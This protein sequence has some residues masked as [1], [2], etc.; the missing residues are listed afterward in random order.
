M[1]KE[2]KNRLQVLLFVIIFL[3]IILFQDDVR[4]YFSPKEDGA[5]VNTNPPSFPTGNN[6]GNTTNTPGGSTNGNGGTSGS[7]G[8]GTTGTDNGDIGG[9]GETGGD[10]TTGTGNDSGP[11]YVRKEIKLPP[12]SGGSSYTGTGGSGGSTSGAVYTQTATT[13]P[14]NPFGE[15]QRA[16]DARTVEAKL[17]TCVARYGN[18]EFCDKPASLILEV[19]ERYPE[20]S[21][22]G[23]MERAPVI[24]RLI[25]SQILGDPGGIEGGTVPF[26]PT[27]VQ[28]GGSII[29]NMGHMCYDAGNST[30]DS[31]G[32]TGTKIPPSKSGKYCN[33]D[34]VASGS[35]TC[36]ENLRVIEGCNAAID[37]Y[38][39]FSDAELIYLKN[40]YFTELGIPTW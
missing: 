15:Q 27:T 1:K 20:L 25:S 26:S 24:N 39:A 13:K 14:A 8:T 30:S 16:V 38:G 31:G 10:N 33:L 21:G 34:P 36:A 40:K 4:N 29:D 28:A 3:C 19:I 32:A 11:S 12:S 23:V 35:K 6:N 18:A 17:N 22:M 5:P 7:N 37:T 2:T 9:D